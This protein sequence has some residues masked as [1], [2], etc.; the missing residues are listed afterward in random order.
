[1]TGPELRA[2]REKA[3]IKSGALAA[4]MGLGRTRIPQIEAQA[5]VA[6]EVRGKYIAALIELA[7]EAKAVSS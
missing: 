3:G 4:R 6:P 2:Q 5:V 7:A 1:M